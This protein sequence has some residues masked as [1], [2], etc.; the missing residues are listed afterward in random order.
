MT[1]QEISQA[2]ASATTGR[3]YLEGYVAWVPFYSRL[4]GC[5]AAWVAD[6]GTTVLRVSIAV[7]RASDERRYRTR[8]GEW[9]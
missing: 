2:R 7:T 6:D 4:V 5:A 9:G 3:G 8:S 1:R